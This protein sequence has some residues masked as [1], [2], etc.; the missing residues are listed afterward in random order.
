LASLLLA[1]YFLPQRSFFFPSRD[2]ASGRNGGVSLQHTVPHKIVLVHC[3]PR[4]DP[5]GDLD[6]LCRYGARKITRRQSRSVSL[7]SSVNSYASIC[8]RNS[9]DGVLAISI[10][11]SVLVVSK[12]AKVGDRPTS[13][14][15]HVHA[16]FV[17]MGDRFSASDCRFWRGWI[18]DR[19]DVLVRVR[20][21][22]DRPNVGI[23]DVLGAHY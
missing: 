21:L 11:S 23:L 22:T 3:E 9:V 18:L 13:G 6:R 2:S 20:G 15:F 8:Y 16:R 4:G 7:F 5:I 19:C 10:I 14:A 17:W 1:H 12:S